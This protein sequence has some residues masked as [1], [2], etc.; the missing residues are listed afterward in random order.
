M[1][2]VTAIESNEV[3]HTRF[4]NGTSKSSSSTLLYLAFV[5]AAIIQNETIDVIIIRILIRKIHINILICNAS[6]SALSE[7]LLV[8]EKD[9]M[10]N[11]TASDSTTAGE[12]SAI[13]PRL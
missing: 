1:T 8:S 5:I 7:S 2:K 13:L 11:E 9:S 12:K 6:V 4:V 3:I 10:F